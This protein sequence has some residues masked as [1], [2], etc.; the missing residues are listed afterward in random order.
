MSES[1]AS[2]ETNTAKSTLSET[3]EQKL[4][5]SSNSS[6]SWDVNAIDNSLIADLLPVVFD[7]YSEKK[8]SSYDKK[9]SFFNNVK[10]YRYEPLI[11]AAED[12]LAGSTDDNPKC[13]SIVKADPSLLDDVIEAK[14]PFGVVVIGDLLQIAAMAGD[15]DLKE[16]ITQ[17]KEQGL[18]ERL[19]KAGGLSPEA[20]AKKLEIIT[21]KESMCQNEKRNISHLNAL[22][23]CGE[24]LLLVFQ[25]H[26]KYK[27]D[28]YYEDITALRESCKNIMDQFKD[29]LSDSKV[30][31][32]GYIFDPKVL[33]YAIKLYNQHFS[34]HLAGSSISNVWL[35]NVFGH[36]QSKL[37]YRYRHLIRAGMREWVVNKKIPKRILRG[38]YSSTAWDDLGQNCFLDYSASGEAA[39]HVQGAI[40]FSWKEI[41]NLDSVNASAI[42]K[43]CNEKKTFKF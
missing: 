31:T 7:Y 1:R 21:S 6:T 4:V 33:N 35:V 29:K 13:L 10:N 9:L 17:E 20:V 11:E 34:H 40:N 23:E 15:F 41:E 16:G 18:V 22:E 3:T 32:S 26:K 30:I 38:K 25:K 27:Y 12:I 14:D 19:A 37:S 8:R 5:S 43:L 24:S 39:V 2:L 28:S 36:V 42:N